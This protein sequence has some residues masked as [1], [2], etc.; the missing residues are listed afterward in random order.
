MDWEFDRSP[1]GN[2]ALTGELNLTRTREFTLGLAFGNSQHHAVSTL[3]Q[4]LSIP[5]A[6]HYK[7][8][9]EQWERS[10]VNIFPLDKVSGDEGNLGRH[11]RVVHI[12]RGCSGASKG[13]MESPP[14]TR[15]R[16]PSE[17]LSAHRLFREQGTRRRSER[18][19]WTP[20]GWVIATCAETVPKPHLF[21]ASE[22]AI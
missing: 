21:G 18:Q 20:G 11:R 7:R 13:R 3:L 9:G 5:F 8:Y 4:S 15:R 6:E 16:R 2:I 17:N 14:S 10:S 1:D 12:H 22:V 19:C